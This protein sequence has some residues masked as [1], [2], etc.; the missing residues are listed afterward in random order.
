M[1]HFRRITAVGA[2]AVAVALGCGDPLGLPRPGIPNVVDTVSLYALSGTPIA[3]PSAYRLDLKLPVRT[4]QSSLFDFAFDIDTTGRAR[5]LPTGALGLT[6][7]SGGQVMAVPFDSIHVAPD[8]SYQ[9]DSALVVD[10]GDVAV[11]HSQP[12][13]CSFGIPAFFYA[14]LRVLAV[15]TTAG[16]NGRRIDFEILVDANCGYRGLDPGL[17]P[18]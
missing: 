11:M 5:L 4:D 9:L 18:R 8:R 17:P 6:R 1:R 16:P 15:D 10:V 13:T 12:A 3:T 7:S 2:L 14:K